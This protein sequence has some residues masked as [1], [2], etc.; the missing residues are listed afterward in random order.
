MKKLTVSILLL[1][2]SIPIFSCGY[3]PYG[4]DIRYCLLRPEYFQFEAYKLFY[5][6]ANQWGLNGYD[7]EKSI[8]EFYE[9][10]IL[11]W[12]NYT[13][14]KVAL[15]AIETFN[16]QFK[17]TDIHP[18]SGNAFL[19]YLYHN[20][21]RAV[22]QYLLFSKKC[23]DFNA[24]QNEDVWERNRVANN[25]KRNKFYSQLYAQY[26]KET[27]NYLKRKYAFQCI[28]FSYYSG[29]MKSVTALFNEAFAHSKKD[30][31]YY[32]S[33]YF[34]CF[35]SGTDNAVK[36]A[37]LFAQSPEK[38]K[39]AF[40][41]FHHDFN[42]KSAL[43]QAHTAEDIAAVYAYASCQKVD[44]NLDYLKIMYANTSN[45]RILDF[46]LLR[47][48]NK[49]E[50]WIYTPYYSNYLPSI[51]NSNYY[52]D[53]THDK[54]STELLRS[55][56]EHDRLYAQ[57][58]LD[59]VNSVDFTKVNNPVL[60]KAAQIQ[61][62]F[63]TRKYDACLSAIDSFGTKYSKEKVFV[64]IEQIKALC[65]T[66]NQSYGKA[67]LK[68][69]VKPIFLRN[70]EDSRFVFALGRE[71]EFLG[72]LPDAMALISSIN[73]R[74]SEYA[75]YYYES[76]GVEWQGNRLKTTD[77]LSYFYEY[78]DYVDFVYSASELQVIVNK[79]NTPIVSDFDKVL[80]QYLLKDKN[81][82][83]DL[84][85][86]K[87]LRESQLEN[88]NRVFCSLSQDYWDD[89]YNPWERNHF[90][91]EM[92]FDENPFYSFKY[93]AD[94]IPHKE[95][96]RVTK[97]SVTS[98]LIA[99]LKKA[100]TSNEPDRDYYYF[101]VANCFFN[102]SESGN[103]WMMR[104]YQSSSSGY[105]EGYYDVSYVDEKEYRTK[106]LAKKYYECAL[107]QAK[108]AKF[109]ALCLRM[110]DFVEKGYPDDF[111]KVNAA[112]PNYLSDLSNCDHLEEY[113]NARR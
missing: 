110:I 63:M 58:L 36:V 12:Y 73:N 14:K 83:I 55:R 13:Q 95:K 33:M 17:L 10:N 90:S 61:L 35:T 3:T 11:D 112:Y 4:E 24:Q 56:S 30:Y 82:L 105:N 79:L 41:Y 59:F 16:Y 25:F 43:N 22:L 42:F 54:I 101:L 27:S 66:A 53:D 40:Y 113:F 9:S 64:Q 77:N 37:N 76:Y 26:Q 49:V 85:G 102:M 32:W 20:K 5:Y 100:T 69:V 111:P 108:T 107:Q 28:R 8:P 38:A 31:I 18:K 94:F 39:A 15:S 93:T 81:Y 74:E 75:N 65:C 21:K 52:W 84:L 103:S 1:L 89:N 87:Y 68:D 50:D 86:T 19:D 29:D 109:K 72:N 97:L 99:Y 98:H 96:F 62:L 106:I 48:I 6:N 92:I 34:T 60:W 88:A 67:I 23:E 44:K 104:R 47:E 78:F 57:Q 45:M 2:S 46:M 7:E 51:E 70:R 71:L 91:E 80:Y